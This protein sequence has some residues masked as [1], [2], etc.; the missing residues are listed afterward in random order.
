MEK[1]QK[2]KK[3]LFK[4]ILKWT[5]ISFLLLLIA[6]ILIP[7]FFKDQLKQMVIDEVNK[8][9]NAK[10]TIGDFDLTFISTFPT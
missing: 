8:N 9:L 7:I 1:S 3:S 4:R 2:K 6:L 5:G 10:L